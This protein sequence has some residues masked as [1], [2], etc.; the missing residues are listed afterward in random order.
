MSDKNYI[1]DLEARVLSLEKTIR[2]LR[3]LIGR[4]DSRASFLE[5]RL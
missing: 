3:A 1:E 2:V 4:L 5:G